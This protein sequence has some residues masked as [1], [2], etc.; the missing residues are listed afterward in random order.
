MA[1][2]YK[3]LSQPRS[4]QDPATS[5]AA[6]KRTKQRVLILSSRGVTYRHRH[7]LNDLYSLLPHSRKDAKLDTKTKLYQLNELAE[8]Y[9]CN[10]VGKPDLT[11]HSQRRPGLMYP[12]FV[13]RSAQRKRLVHMDEQS[14]KWTD[15]QIPSSKPYA[16]IQSFGSVLALSLINHPSTHNV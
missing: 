4:L 2:V 1:T 6:P 14:P 7:L 5:V 16:P 9:N 8:L 12:G 13:L 3:A 15:C 10:N 11:F